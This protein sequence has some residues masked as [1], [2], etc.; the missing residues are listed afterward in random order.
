MQKLLIVDDEVSICNSL[1]FALEDE[2]ET[3]TAEDEESAMKIVSSMDISIVLL[4]LKLGST[5]GITLLKKIK[6]LSP[7]TA[8]IIMTA[9]G[10]IES[11][12]EAIKSGAFII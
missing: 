6:S 9:Y 2:Y 11:S 5:D 1:S 7:R 4:D 10:S 12:I 3:Y 8:V